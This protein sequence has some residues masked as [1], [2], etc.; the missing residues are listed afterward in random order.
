M[1]IIDLTYPIQEGMQKFDAYWHPNVSIEKLGSI[2]SVGRESRKIILGTHTGTH[3]DAP[4]HFI[5]NG[6]SVD[7]IELEKLVGEITIVDF[8]HF[9]KNT[10][11][12]KEELKNLKITKKMLF[13]F[14]WGKN[15][16]GENF[17]KNYPYFSR[18]A[19][20]YLVLKNVEL[21]A[22]DTP[23]PDDSRTKL[24]SECDSEIHKI[25]LKNNIIL[26][27][28]LANLDKI[29]ENEGW[30]ISVNPL[31]IKGADGSP[32]RVYLFK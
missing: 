5:E 11:I 8:S 31:A 30:R 21:I 20:E 2:N 4:L 23:S 19:A 10:Q 29:N 16:I 6:K 32:A 27:E 14:G 3:V 22:Y 26:V 24:G 12:T 9:E 17:Y 25:F 28:Y 15:W 7:E 1:K 18:E 13:K